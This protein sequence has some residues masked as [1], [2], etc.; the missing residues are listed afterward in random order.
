MKFSGYMT[1]PKK[2][3]LHLSKL[4]AGT[5]STVEANVSARALVKHQHSPDFLKNSDLLNSYLQIVEN[6][7]T[8]C[9][10]S[11]AQ[12][13]GFTGVAPNQGTSLLLSIVSYLISEEID[14]SVSY[15]V[16]SKK[17]KNAN[18]QSGVHYATLMKKGICVLD[19]NFHNPALHKI[20]SLANGNGLSDLLVHKDAPKLAGT[21]L[22]NS[23]FEVVTAGQNQQA[24]RPISNWSAIEPA[25]SRLRSRKKYIF[26]DIPPLLKYADALRLCKYC[27]AVAL[28]V[29]ANN[30]R[31][32]VVVQTKRTLEKNAVR[33][34][35]GVLTNRKYFLPGWLYK[36]L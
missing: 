30:A 3:P 15:V 21:F 7:Q 9:Q 5:T 13:I 34:L 18:G 24:V 29:R 20:F 6:I 11:D 19:C 31:R 28:V 2:R 14:G 12:V 35:G 33:V 26:L 10:Q 1:R 25:L 22:F 36:K 32:E 27:D 8:V 17:G 23:N 16:P 4:T